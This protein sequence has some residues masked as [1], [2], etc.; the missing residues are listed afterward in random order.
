[1][2]DT[3]LYHFLG[4]EL[5]DKNLSNAQ[6]PSSNSGEFVLVLWEQVSNTY[7][8]CEYFLELKAFICPQLGTGE[9]P[10]SK[11]KQSRGEKKARKAMSKLGLKGVPGVHRVTIRKSKNILFVIQKPDV[12]KSPA[13]DLYII[14][15][16][17]K[18]LFLI[19]HVFFIMGVG[20]MQC[21]QLFN[22]IAQYQSWY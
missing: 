4:M 1:M 10:V 14:F 19:K 22:K 17:A 5:D 3:Q 6:K 13:S 2:V 7:Q 15:G 11:A 21:T 20:Y 18:V 12:Y 8:K 9:E 16:E